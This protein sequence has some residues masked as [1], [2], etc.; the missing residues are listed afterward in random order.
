M[1]ILTGSKADLLKPQ[2][3]AH[4]ILSALFDITVPID[5]SVVVPN[6]ELVLTVPGTYVMLAAVRAQ[7][8]ISAGANGFVAFDLRTTLLSGGSPGTL[9]NGSCGISAQVGQTTI[10]ADSVG[11]SV[12]LLVVTEPLKVETF[13]VRKGIL[14]SPTFTASRILSDGDGD[15]TMTAI[16]LIN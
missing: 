10:F 1:G 13:L 12:S 2:A 5:Q 15:T 11:T 16:Q 4:Q 9:I 8:T 14:T 7:V 6:F 3:R